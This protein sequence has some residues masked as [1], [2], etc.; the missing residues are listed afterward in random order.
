M[1]PLVSDD[2]LQV[3]RTI[4]S[5]FRTMFVSA[6]SVLFLFKLVILHHSIYMLVALMF[7]CVSCFLIYYAGLRVATLPIV[8]KAR[9]YRFISISLVLAICFYGIA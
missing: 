7:S 8:V 9:C 6:L 5:W 2:K 3:E 4:L 1:T